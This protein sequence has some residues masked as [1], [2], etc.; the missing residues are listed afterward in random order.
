MMALLVLPERGDC[1]DLKEQMVFLDQKDLLA[2][3]E[4]TV[5]LDILDREE[6]S[7]FKGRWVHQVLPESS[8]LRVHLERLALWESGAILDPQVHLESKVF[9]APL[10]KK[11][12]KEI[13]VLQEVL[14]RMD[15][16]D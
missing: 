7:V 3:L 6:K 16:Q 8:A 5:C 14:E 12:P 4:K 9:L 13:L 15:L 11:E 2:L 10:E 1:L